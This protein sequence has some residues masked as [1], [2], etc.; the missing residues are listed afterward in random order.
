MH[1]ANCHCP[2]CCAGALEVLEFTDRGSRFASETSAFERGAQD[3]GPSKPTPTKPPPASASPSNCAK[4]LKGL[5]VAV[6]GGGFAG[7]MAARTLCRQ[8]AEVTVFEARSQVGGRVQSDYGH[9][10]KGRITELGAELVGS[11]HTRWCALALEYGL[12]LVNRMDTEL[13]RGQQL[14]VAMVLDKALDMDQIRALEEEQVARVLLPISKLA[15][16]IKDPSRPWDE[17]WL[18]PYDAL[19]VADQL[20]KPTSGTGYDQGYG[21]GK[22]ERLWKAIELLLVNDN[23]KRLEELNFLGLLCLVRGGQFGTIK[24]ADALMGYWNELE[25]YRCADGCQTLAFRMATDIQSSKYRCEVVLRRAVTRIDVDKPLGGKSVSVTSKPVVGIAGGKAVFGAPK[26]EG[27][28][29]VIF[30]IPPSVWS[31]V[32]ILPT[33]PATALGLMEMGDA[34]KFFSEVGERFWLKTRQAPYGG[35]LALGQVW[36]GTDNQTRIGDQGVVLSVFAGGRTP[37]PTEKDFRRELKNL[38][39]N[40]P[41]APKTY[42]A[43]WPEQPFIRAGFVSPGKNQIFKL[44]KAL[45]EPYLGRIFFAGEHTQ[46]DHFGYMEGALRSGERAANLLMQQV[47]AAPEMVATAAR[48]AHQSGELRW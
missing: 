8:G 27:F 16:R 24:R 5:S 36:E 17:A 10:S 26:V 37:M 43:N 2:A 29:R 7:L 22:G 3:P 30:A 11:I 33:H 47:C 1:Q 4:K 40:Y 13:Y 9:F 46:M 6:V 42:L 45:N 20:A 44:G 48:V 19:S 32:D 34:V 35:S 18:K 25:I 23:V 12:A 28:D 38:Y 31:G 39:P 41:A 14:N 15:S 21:V